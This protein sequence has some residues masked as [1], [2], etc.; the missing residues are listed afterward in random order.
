MK[1]VIIYT[2]VSTDEQAK[3][4][5]SLSHQKY[6]L[7]T[8]CKHHNLNILGHYQDD[9]S[10][11]DF[12][13]PEFAKLLNYCR[14]NKRIIDLLLFTRWDRFSRNTTDSYNML[15]IFDDLGIATNS[16]EQPLDL[17]QPDSKLMLA[18][19][20]SSSEIENDKNSIRTKEGMRRAM[21]EGYW[22]GHPPRGYSRLKTENNKP[23]LIKNEEA[24]II[25]KI[26]IEFASGLYSAES[27]RKKYYGQIKIK[28]QSF[29][30]LLRG[31]VYAGRIF[32]KEWR[33][34]DSE[35]VEA[36]HD[37]IISEDIFTKVQM[38]L[39]KNKKFK[40]I[41]ENPEFILRRHLICNQ[42][43]NKLTGS[44][45]TSRSKQKYPYYHCQKNCN[46]RF[47]TKLAE[48]SFQSFL[49][50]YEIKNEVGELFIK[51]MDVAIKEK[52]SGDD[53]VLLKLNKNITKHNKRLMNLED[54]FMDGDIDSIDYKKLS[55]R[56]RIRIASLETEKSNIIQLS[57]TR[58]LGIKS[59]VKLLSNLSEFYNKIDFHLKKRLIGSIFKNG[60][61]FNGKKYRTIEETELLN[62]IFL[63][64]SELKKRTIK[65]AGKN[66]RLSSYAP[67]LGLEP[68]TL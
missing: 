16:V 52:E 45:S 24:P 44:F 4:G 35:I 41:K 18:V 49:K 54:K 6:V 27:L 8:Y 10:A 21:R 9:Y 53:N 50:Q 7:E 31:H 22:V 65:K 2:R 46:E 55:S 38:L 58:L 39:S 5:Y 13:R 68:R 62:L 11:K 37:P 64:V 17:T 42:C 30:N 33:K 61:I 12:E 23:T 57:K 20:L 34:E 47:S 19:Y 25:K 63:K 28:K 60:L 40:I 59:T 43:G 48:S 14:L 29:L 36:I 26:F 15:R 67:P 3:S 1:N 32:I 66:T 51:M 56:Y